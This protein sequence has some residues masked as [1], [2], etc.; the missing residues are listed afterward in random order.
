MRHE[1]AAVLVG[2]DDYWFDG[3]ERLRYAES[4]CRKLAVSL[5]RERY[6]FSRDRVKL[7][8]S[9]NR[10]ATQPCRSNL[11][12][13]GSLPRPDDS[14]LDLFV[15]FFAGHGI[16][17]DG[18]TYLVP[19]DAI[20]DT[21]HRQ[22]VVDTC[23]PLEA[24]LERVSA[25]P[26]LRRLI[27]LDA[28]H[29]GAVRGQAAG[30]PR[31]FGLEVEQA[32]EAV[33]LSACNVN[34]ESLEDARLGG[35]I[36]TH[37]WCRALEDAEPS[38]VDR[39]ITV[40]DVHRRA[41]R[42][43]VEHATLLRR[44]QQPRIWTSNSP[45]IYLTPSTGM[46]EQPDLP[47][48]LTDPISRTQK[49]VDILREMRR[50]REVF[51]GYCVRIRARLSSF[52]ISDDEPFVHAWTA[53]DPRLHDILREERDALVDLFLRGAS[54]KVILS[55][56]LSEYL[57]YPDASRG[58][59]TARF[60][61]LRKFCLRVLG[62]EDLTS[63][64]EIIRLPNPERNQLLLG[65]SYL[66]EGRKLKVSEGG[67][68]ATQVIGD[69]EIIENEIKMF[70]TLFENGLTYVCTRK[71]IVAGRGRNRML[72]QAMLEDIE[73]DIGLLKG[74]DRIEASQETADVLPEPPIEI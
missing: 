71:G 18:R 65:N 4:D 20:W 7:L 27:I 3:W 17:H 69:P 49:I 46:H 45:L 59:I 52:A 53:G 58:V 11:L 64:L 60:R 25:V 44:K 40:F 12:Y 2:I 14:P 9:S 10:T 48:F 28:C 73:R 22:P 24:I 30:L 39:T 31:S 70:D 33:V 57:G 74:G 62:G 5:C 23:I 68:D 38:G 16:P 56:N 8:L 41:E 32:R 26:A 15:F 13:D 35:G 21:R 47:P 6:G 61:E 55:W 54:L 1:R 50:E 51:E 43:V 29:G 42:E 36:F 72:L 19:V 66:F 37:F 67:F 63:R 34:E